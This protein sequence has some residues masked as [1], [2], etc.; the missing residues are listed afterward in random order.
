MDW[1]S[2]IYYLIKKTSPFLLFLYAVIP[3][4]LCCY[5]IFPCN[6]DF[7]IAVNVKKYG[8]LHYQY[9]NYMGWGGRY[10]NNAL[11]SFLLPLIINRLFVYKII[12][13]FCILLTFVP[14][15]LFTKAIFKET[16][17]KTER[18]S[19]AMLFF[20]LFLFQMPSPFYAFYFFCGFINYN[21]FVIALLF[22]FYFLIRVYFQKPRYV[23]WSRF[24][25]LLI[26][27][28]MI[29]LIEISVMFV[30]LFLFAVLLVRYYYSRKLDVFLLVCFFSSLLFSVFSVTAP[31]NSI[32]GAYYE[33][34]STNNIFYSMLSS[35]ISTA[36]YSIIWLQNGLILIFTLF[37]IPLASKFCQSGRFKSIVKINPLISLGI[38]LIIL[39]ACFFPPYYATGGKHFP[40]SYLNNIYF[41]FLAGWFY[42]ILV[43]VN[44]FQNKYKAVLKTYPSY[45]YI[46][47]FILCL[48]PLKDFNIRR[49][50]NE[51]YSG[52]CA[53]Y[54][55]EMLGRYELMEKSRTDTI[56]FRKLSV[57]PQ[58]VCHSDLTSKSDSWENIYFAKYYNKKSVIVSEK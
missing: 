58:T 47:L 38:F 42:N 22:L 37:F 52:E 14:V 39:A 8:Y 7:E 17:S 54:N 45:V 18:Y 24:I 4:L 33:G 13:F 15:L 48:S 35:G 41:V 25:I 43:T 31:G 40:T 6:D 49:A 44:Y 1:I 46:V 5:F 21:L 12:S 3:F 34:N 30:N 57:T 10:S 56:V 53:T 36:K 28:V 55:N 27:F 16:L 29:G 20:V 9:F 51:L 50:Y 11:L 32:R 19:I 23:N 2:K 26:I